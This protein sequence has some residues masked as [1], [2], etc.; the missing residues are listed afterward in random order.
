VLSGLSAPVREASESVTLRAA[1][2][3]LVLSPGASG[4]VVNLPALA[5]L[6]VGKSFAVWGRGTNTADVLDSVGSLVSKVAPLTL[7]RLTATASE[8]QANE[9]TAPARSA[10]RRVYFVAADWQHNEDQSCYEVVVTAALSLITTLYRE[11]QAVPFDYTGDY[12]V[13]GSLTI[14]V[15]DVDFPGPFDGFVL[16]RY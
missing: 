14:R 7:V 15:S 2:N 5:D 8:W 11:V 1:D 12:G 16:Q 3:T 10:P 13:P 6:P 9:W 4:V